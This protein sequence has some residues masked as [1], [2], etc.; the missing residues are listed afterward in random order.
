MKKIKIIQERKC[1]KCGSVENQINKGFNLS[2]TQKCFCKNCNSHY[3]LNP[4]TRAYP[5]EIRKL[6]IKEYY[7]G[8]TG[9]GVG[10]IHGFNKANVFNW[11][12]KTGDTV[13]K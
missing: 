9:R 6:A 10:K 11:L 12:K 4:K 7:A 2:N 13:D 3:T 5:D 1:T 8:V